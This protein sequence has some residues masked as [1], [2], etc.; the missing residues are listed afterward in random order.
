[1]SDVPEYPYSG[2]EK[3][4]YSCVTFRSLKAISHNDRL[5]EVLQALAV[6]PCEAEDI[7]S[8]G[9]DAL[10][11]IPCSY[12]D[13]RSRGSM[14]LDAALTT[15]SEWVRRRED[16]SSAVCPIGAWNPRLAAWCCF[17]IARQFELVIY[18]SLDK[19][20]ETAEKRASNLSRLTELFFIDQ[21]VSV[22][23]QIAVRKASRYADSYPVMNAKIAVAEL[24]QLDDRTDYRAARIVSLCT[25]I[26]S[27]MKDYARQ[28]GYDEVNSSFRDVIS[29]RCMLFPR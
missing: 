5:H 7:R 23:L 27:A 15:I 13:F 19:R 2:Y 16:A 8:A 25:K 17:P 24:A 28:E 9:S 1:M 3:S 12:D 21:D 11:S 10:E 26:M 6:D 4:P 14:E 22:G 29:K 20:L 18:R